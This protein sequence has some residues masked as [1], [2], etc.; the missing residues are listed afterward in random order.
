MTPRPTPTTRASILVRYGGANQGE[1][2]HI[3]PGV[4]SL[5]ADVDAWSHFA[6]ISQS[7][8]LTLVG[9]IQGELWAGPA[10]TASP[11]A[12]WY[13]MG[14]TYAVPNPNSATGPWVNFIAPSPSDVNTLYFT[15][16]N[17]FEMS[18]NA[19]SP[20][21]NWVHTIPFND[22]I[23]LG[24]VAV[25]PTD[26]KTVYMAKEGFV[27]GQKIYL[28]HDG[29][30][31]WTNISGNMP[32]CPVNWIAVDPV[33]PN[34]L[35]VATDLGVFYAGDGG[36]P[37]ENWSVVG[38]GLPDCPVL[39]VKVSNTNPRRLVAATYGR[40]AWTL[41]IGGTAPAPAPPEAGSNPAPAP[42]YC[43]VKGDWWAKALTGTNAITPRRDMGAVV[44]QGNMW[45]LGGRTGNTEQVTDA[46]YS[47]DGNVWTQD[48]LEDGFTL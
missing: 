24:A 48:V 14:T 19:F 13:S 4:D 6:V 11:N 28:S 18:T 3:G 43:T 27:D 12:G 42:L 33:D 23:S 22:N 36:V 10:D 26:P 21:P 7:D 25:S 32:N 16:G 30:T 44:Y 40:G 37:G 31:I 35:Y 2:H 1:I 39:Q 46:W 29:G 20:Q 17:A 9:V 5:V 38:Y 34:G 47:S 41:G 8:P 45:V 15:N